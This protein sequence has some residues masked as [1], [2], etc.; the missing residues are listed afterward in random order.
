MNEQK[1][2]EIQSR[3]YGEW[4][5]SKGH[6]YRSGRCAAVVWN[7]PRGMTNSQCSR[8]PGYGEGGLYCKQHAKTVPA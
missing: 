6:P 5:G 1:R 2:S 4:A 8:K 3:R 7:G